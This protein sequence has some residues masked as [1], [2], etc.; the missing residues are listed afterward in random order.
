MSEDLNKVAM[1]LP[2]GPG[3][4]RVEIDG[5]EIKGVVAVQVDHD[6]QSGTVL[7]IAMLADITSETAQA[8][9]EEAP[10]EDGEWEDVGRP[11]A[12]LVYQK[13]TKTGEQRRV[14]A[15]G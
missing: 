2:I 12:G 13:N 4:P 14:S 10:A 6:P 11:I 7:H 3:V 8:V 5:V 9:A 1:T 15:A